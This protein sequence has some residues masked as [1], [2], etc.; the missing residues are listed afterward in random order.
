MS[1]E[2]HHSV[3]TMMLIC[4]CMY[5]LCY[6]VLGGACSCVH[7]WRLSHVFSITLHFIFWDMACTW[8]Y[9]LLFW[10]GWLTRKPS[11]SACLPSLQ[12]VLELQIC[13]SMPSFYKG[14]GNSE[15]CS[16]CVYRK[17]LT[18]WGFSLANSG[19]LF[20]PSWPILYT[21]KCSESQGL[22]QDAIPLA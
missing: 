19:F 18:H 13:A 12:P 5:G 4:I 14:T 7:T 6:R 3:T 8:T 1:C 10:Q 9:N 17:Y 15:L 22:S 21:M 11:R 16:L 20:S 2:Q